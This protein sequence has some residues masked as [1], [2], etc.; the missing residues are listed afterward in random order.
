MASEREILSEIDGLLTGYWLTDAA[1]FAS[2]LFHAVH[3]INWIGFYFN[4]SGRLR[5]G[6][7]AG[8]PACTEIAFGRGVCGTAFAS[9]AATVV[10]DVHEFPG[11]IVCDPAS[12][13]ELVLPVRAG[14]RVVGVF[15]VD[16]PSIGR[17][18]SEDVAFF[19]AA[20]EKLTAG[21]ATLAGP[22]P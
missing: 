20:L 11:H 15:D 14:D 8:K 4:D 18:K 6:P 17:F 22:R 5:L 2:H 3:D 9:G 16:S 10:D 1:N 21:W 19:S 7:F 12:R 13:S